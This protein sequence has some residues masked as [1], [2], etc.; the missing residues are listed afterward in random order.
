MY[1]IKRETMKK[2]IIT[3]TSLLL[4]VACNNK[5]ELESIDDGTMKFDVEHPAKVTRATSAG[6]EEGDEISLFAVEYVNGV[7][8]PLQI[9][10]NFINNETLTCTSG[11]W[12]PE[13]KLYWGDTALDFYAFYPKIDKLQSSTAH[14]VEIETDQRS[15]PAD[16]TMS[17]YEASDF[18][19]AKAENVQQT[20][21]N[22]KLQFKHLM[23]KVTVT[24][25]KGE[26]FEGEFPEDACVNIYNTN[27]TAAI[28][29]AQGSVCKYAY[30]QKK[31]IN[32]RKISTTEFEAIV[33]PQFISTLTPLIEITMG[34]ISY[35]LD[36]SI[37]FMPGYQHDISIIINT[38]PNQEKIEI[39]IDGTINDWVDNNN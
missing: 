22:V 4:M 30:G 19:F 14:I 18:L 27:T 25:E 36:Y 38:S 32:A 35:L 20:D 5:A 7:A 16:G 1:K 9:A 11:V 6:F 23:S 21:G 15:I 26:T 33:V 12:A 2:Y 28:N 29:L 13:R 8:Q 34:G 24:L 17:G 31:T 3:L 37:S 39:S 10:A